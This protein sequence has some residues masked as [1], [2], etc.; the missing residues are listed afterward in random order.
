[1]S[2]SGIHQN[3]RKLGISIVPLFILLLSSSATRAQFDHFPGTTTSK[4]EAL[5]KEPEGPF[6]YDPVDPEFW[7]EVTNALSEDNFTKMVTLGGDILL[8]EK[9]GTDEAEEA[10]LAVGM[11]LS[12]LKLSFA[13]SVIFMDLGKSRNGT[14]IGEAA[15]FEL[16]QIAQQYFYD[17][18]EVQS[19]FV[20]TE[21]GPLH[22]DIQSFIGFHVG[23][24]NLVSGYRDWADEAFKGI[25]KDSYWD[26]EMLY[27]KSL[28]EIARDHFDVGQKDLESL[29]DNPLV[30][31]ELKQR[32]LLQLARLKFEQGD[33]TGAYSL[34][35]NLQFPQRELGRVYLERAWTKFYMRDYSKALGLLAVAQTPIFRNALTP[36]IYILKM[37][38]LRELCHY[39]AALETAGDFR[40]EF[41]GA[42]QS[43]KD[44]KDLNKNFRIGSGALLDQG[45]QY[46]ANFVGQIRNEQADFKEYSWE[47]YPFYSKL[48]RAYDKKEAQVRDRIDRE[49]DLY[50]R[51]TAKELLESEEQVTFLDYTAKL[52]SLRIVRKGESRDY[53]S[54]KINYLKFNRIYWPVKD[55][56]W[57]DE[58]E[59]YKVL[60]RSRCGESQ[61]APAGGDDL[62]SEVDKEKSKEDEDLEAE[63]FE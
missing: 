18:E 10:K 4:P 35:E 59:T 3:S 44:R 26:H 51:Q 57:T 27:L 30:T 34:Y 49:L 1:M 54:E 37:L 32:S 23:L 39:E 16:T 38:I 31:T 52:D 22:S 43:V 5:T 24:Y 25:R 9:E 61:L 58:L 20:S 62:D 41:G 53:K 11:G 7:K 48:S 56:H 2:A 8:E 42:I 21:F 55:E 63:G 29:R 47:D 40:A 36:E 33:F 60:I 45:L 6:T 15:L 19:L 13:A 50:T 46:W 28:G 12:K 17:K 14:K